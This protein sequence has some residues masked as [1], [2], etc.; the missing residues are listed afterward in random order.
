MKT[1]AMVGFALII[2]LLLL[3]TTSCCHCPLQPAQVTML[4]SDGEG[5]FVDCELEVDRE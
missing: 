5:N 1:E 2:L 4:C 3:A